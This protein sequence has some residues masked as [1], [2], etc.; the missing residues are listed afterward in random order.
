MVLDEKLSYR[1]GMK[2]KFRKSNVNSEYYI[3][4]IVGRLS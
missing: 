1:R 3:C 4:E 2:V